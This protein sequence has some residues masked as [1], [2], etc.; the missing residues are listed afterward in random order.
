MR[1]L[2]SVF[3]L[4]PVLALGAGC[5]PVLFSAEIDAPAVCIGGMALEFPPGSFDAS[6]D[7]TI[8]A[9]DLGVPDDD[10]FDLHV[11]VKS[12]SLSP[13]PGAGD[14]SFVDSVSVHAKA[15]DPATTLPQ[16]SI[17]DMDSGDMQDDGS[18][19][20]EPPAPVAIG[21]YLLAGAVVFA[22]QASGDRPESVSGATMEVCVHANARF[23]RPR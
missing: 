15:G 13:L 23:E 9:D 17:G 20:L 19:Y 3:A 10:Q 22:V 2:V 1:T 12:L 6:T 16:V 7:E 18:L 11:S 8:S 21:Q 4:L 5:D 14:L